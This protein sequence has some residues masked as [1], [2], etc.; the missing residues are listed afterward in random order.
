MTS[1]FVQ[2]VIGHNITKV[3]TRI[4]QAGHETL[5]HLMSLLHLFLRTEDPS[6]E[7]SIG[8]FFDSA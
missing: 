5:D 7:G 6:S 2:R 8:M 1:T 4:L 3:Y